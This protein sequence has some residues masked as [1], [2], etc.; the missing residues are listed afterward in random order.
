MQELINLDMV[1]M[2]NFP[3]VGL[4]T[5]LPISILALALYYLWGD[6][7][8]NDL[9]GLLGMVAFVM[10][11]TLK[12]SENSLFS[13]TP[14]VSSFTHHV[15]PITVL[16][17]GVACITLFYMEFIRQYVTGQEVDY[18]VGFLVSGELE[19]SEKLNYLF[20]TV[21]LAPLSEEFFFRFILLSSICLLLR[22]KFVGVIL[23]SLLFA[24]GHEDP[25]VAF[26][27][28]ITASIVLLKYM[29]IYSAIIFHTIYN[30]WIYT[31]EVFIVPAFFFNDWDFAPSGNIGTIVSIMALAVSFLALLIIK[32]KEKSIQ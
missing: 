16:A 12:K 22:N 23:S 19:V 10:M 11:L 31:V 5:S 2:D 24:Y 21:I 7:G 17:I 28:G 9:R 6:M 27:L 13:V 15:F 4:K 29:S 26:S 32:R 18:I 30:L 14:Q 20:E 8:F 3:T 25:V 1:Q